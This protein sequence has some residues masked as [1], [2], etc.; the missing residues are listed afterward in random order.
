MYQLIIQTM[1]DNIQDSTCLYYVFEQEN[2]TQIILIHLEN[3]DYVKF[4]RLDI[5]FITTHTCVK[6]LVSNS[7]CSPYVINYMLHA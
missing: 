2:L 4:P 1:I 3:F 7:S 5:I 6:N